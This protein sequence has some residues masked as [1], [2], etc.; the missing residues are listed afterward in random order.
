MSSVGKLMVLT[1]GNVYAHVYDAPVC[2]KILIFLGY[3]LHLDILIIILQ[4]YNH[5]LES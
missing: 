3:G 2:I 5:K 4:C 1:A